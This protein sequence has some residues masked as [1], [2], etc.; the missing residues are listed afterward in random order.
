MEAVTE[1]AIEAAAKVAVGPTSSP[2]AYTG[3][4]HI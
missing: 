3:N 1:V 2:S 4:K